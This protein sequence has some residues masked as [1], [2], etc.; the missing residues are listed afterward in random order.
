MP[1]PARPSLPRPAGELRAALLRWYDRARRRLP[2]RA[3][4]GAPADPY[5]VLLSE[6][7]LQQTTVAT[8]AERFGTFRAR[9]P[10][11]AALAAAPLDEVLHAWQGLGY[12]RRARALHALAREI[13][14]RRGAELPADPDE[15][16]GLPGIGPYTAAA[17]A[18]IAFERPVVP[19]DGNVARVLSRLVALEQPLPA[20]LPDLRQLGASLADGTRPGDF[21]QALMDLGATLCRPTAP[22]CAACPWRGA[23]RA[24]AQG[25]EAGLPVRSPRPVRP[26]R[27]ATAFLVRRADGAVL[28][29]RRPEQGLL[30]GLYEL[31]STPWTGEAPWPTRHALAYAPRA[32]GWRPLPGAVRHLFTHLALEVAVIAGD[33]A[34]HAAGLFVTPGAL[35]AVALPTLTRKL[36]R[37]GGIRA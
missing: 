20:A 25:R 14:E 32:R 15:L 26:L 13:V 17:V 18:A 2:W 35:D 10:S 8:V 6:V 21:A 24:H 7:M 16:A 29:R 33:R 3:E 34:D 23:C 36:L 30:A 27:H 9:F 37:H 4:P 5:S 12:Y 1:A 11:L 28:L 22:D 31:P 19:V